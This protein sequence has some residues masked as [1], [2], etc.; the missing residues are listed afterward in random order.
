M[1]ASPNGKYIATASTGG[2][3]KLWNDQWKLL[4]ET[5]APVQSLF[6]VRDTMY[7]IHNDKCHMSVHTHVGT[8]V[9][10]SSYHNNE[11]DI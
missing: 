10:F 8:V 3:I 9:D 1:R 2:E 4:A 6:H 7:I 5:T 11:R